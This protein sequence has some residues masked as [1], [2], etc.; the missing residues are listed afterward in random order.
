MA[1]PYNSDCSDIC[2]DLF[3]KKRKTGVHCKELRDSFLGAEWLQMR[4]LHLQFTLVDVLT[5]LL[6]QMP[7]LCAVASKATG[8]QP[9]SSQQ[10]FLESRSAQQNLAA[11]GQASMGSLTIQCYPNKGLAGL[12]MDTEN[13]LL[14]DR[15][16]SDIIQAADRLDLLWFWQRKVA[17]PDSRPAGKS[18]ALEAG[19]ASLLYVCSWIGAG[20]IAMSILQSQSRCTFKILPRLKFFWCRWLLSCVGQENL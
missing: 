6:R 8:G 19:G 3:G 11:L 12:S 20:E 5:R 15:H 10:D 7:Q 17:G 18:G 14:H 1:F 9:V 4:R 2:A 13:R 16:S